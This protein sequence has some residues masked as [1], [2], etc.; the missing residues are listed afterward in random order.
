M[1]EVVSV[2]AVTAAVS[3]LVRICGNLMIYITKQPRADRLRSVT[4]IYMPCSRQ[5]H[6][7]NQCS[8]VGTRRKFIPGM[9]SS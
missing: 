8:D 2:S 9:R 4:S 7:Q 3:Y 1:L 5:T 6:S